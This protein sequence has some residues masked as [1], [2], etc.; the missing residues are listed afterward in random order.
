MSLALRLIL[1]DPGR[2][3]TDEEIEAAVDRVRAGLE[4]AGA[5]PREATP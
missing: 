3:L 2:T 1:A 4:A 5:R